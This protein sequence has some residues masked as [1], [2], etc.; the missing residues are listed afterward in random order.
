MASKADI[1]NETRDNR[2]LAGG[3]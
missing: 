1:R 3:R 2:A